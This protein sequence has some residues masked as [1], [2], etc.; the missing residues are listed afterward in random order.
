MKMLTERQH[1]II[2]NVKISMLV[3]VSG[4]FDERAQSI[5]KKNTPK[6]LQTHLRV[7][8]YLAHNQDEMLHL[9]FAAL[10]DV[11]HLNKGKNVIHQTTLHSASQ[12]YR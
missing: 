5:N 2:Q 3:H 11:R 10:D 4:H 7:E 1:L 8:P 12:L 9:A 6:T